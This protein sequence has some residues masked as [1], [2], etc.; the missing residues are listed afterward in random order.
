MNHSEIC[1]LPGPVGSPIPTRVLTN[2]EFDP[3]PQTPDQ[4]RV[5]T[6]MGTLS[7]RYGRAQGLVPGQY[8]RTPSGLAAG[9]MAMNM[10]YGDHFRVSH[11]EAEYPDEAEKQWRSLAGQFVFD[12]QTH[13][14]H[15][16]YKRNDVLLLRE[17]ARRKLNPAI[18]R[19]VSSRDQVRFRNFFKELFLESDTAAAILSS[20][21]ADNPEDWF[22]N[23]NQMADGCSVINGI[24]GHQRL[25]NHALIAPGHP[26]WLDEIDRAAAELKPI[27]WKCYPV[28][29]PFHYSRHP[30]RLDDEQLMYPAY[31][32]FVKH[33]ITNVCV[34]KGLM[35]M[36]FL[37]HFANW[38]H[39]SVDDLPKAA[40]DWPELNFIIYHAAFRPSLHVPDEFLERFD[41]TGQMEWVTDLAAI[42]EKIGT[43]NIYAELGTTFGVTAVTHPLIAAALLGV[44][45]RG[46]GEE[47]IIWGT[48]SVYYG[49]PQWQ[50]EALRRIEIPDEM[51]ARH[52]FR[53]LGPPDSGVKQRILGLNGARVF[54]LDPAEYADGGKLAAL[55]REY[56][57]AGERKGEFLDWVLAEETADGSP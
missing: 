31:E 33:G 32:K 19:T 54:G 3:P 15:E 1:R 36:N 47:H 10:V 13:Y 56:A 22:L 18:D 7:I 44:L 8:L 23:N 53:K 2:G 14:V 21:T 42:P 24:L 52:G 49:S 45:V 25:L 48:D 38:K 46:L 5:E 37:K 11:E 34:H 29:D 51:C 28:G 35:P 30:F 4:R 12:V 50:I 40:R 26:G 41:R 16:N 43:R 6:A 57:E 27:G 9:F 17:Y 20:A 55:R 39:G